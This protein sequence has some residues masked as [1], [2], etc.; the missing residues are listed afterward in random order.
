MR[1]L[2]DLG[3]LLSTAQCRTQT[4]NVSF[5]MCK[6]HLLLL[7]TSVHDRDL[8]ERQCQHNMEPEEVSQIPPAFSPSIAVRDGLHSRVSVL[9]TGEA[10][11]M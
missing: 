1:R 8:S 7:T 4:K 3:R 10:E 2:C 9:D 6:C 5:K 11:S